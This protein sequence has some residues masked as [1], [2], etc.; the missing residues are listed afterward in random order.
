MFVFSSLR[1]LPPPCDWLLASPPIGSRHDSAPENQNSFYTS[2]IKFLRFKLYRNKFSFL[3]QLS[4][5]IGT[6]NFSLT[7]RMNPFDTA[8]AIDPSASF[9]VLN[10]TASTKKNGQSEGIPI[11]LGLQPACNQLAVSLFCLRPI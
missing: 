1:G 3:I 9:S 11:P 6:L 4:K 2:V 10:V 7:F 8:V 5:F